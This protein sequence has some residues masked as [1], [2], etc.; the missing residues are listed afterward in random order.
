M[1]FAESN[2]EQAIDF[3]A[4]IEDVARR[5]LGEPNAHLSS[6]YD[7][8]FGAKGSVSVNT[9]KGVFRDY[10]SSVGGGTLDLIGH[11]L[12]LSRHESIQWLRQE[13]F[14]ADGIGR[15]QNVD[16]G[17]SI[18]EVL[19]TNGGKK[20][21]RPR[22]RSFGP[23]GPPRQ[24]GEIR[25]HVYLAKDGTPAKIKIKFESGRYSQWYR[26]EDGWQAKK[27]E[28][29]Q[30]VPYI[31]A[32]LD[33]F[34]PELKDDEIFWPEGEKD[35]DTLNS[36]ELPAFTFGGAGDGLP[37]D[38]T[39]YFTG[40]HLVIPADNDEPGRKHAEEKA[41]RAHA[42]GATRI[43]VFDPKT[44]WPEC[45]DG[46]DIS[47]WFARGG[48]TRERLL[49]AVE[50]LPDWQ[51]EE[52]PRADE[53]ND[54]PS[55]PDYWPTIGVAAFQGIAGDIVRTIEP[56][57]EADPVALLVQTLVMAGN[58]I[59]R[60][61]YYQVESDCHRTNLFTVLVGDSA[62]GRKGTSQGRIRSI[63][64][65]ADQSWT[66]DRIKGGLSSGEGFIEAVRDPVERYDPKEKRFEVVDPGISDK[67]LLI[68]EPEFASAISVMERSGNTLSPLIQRAWDG[69]ILAT[70]TRSPL[71]AT[72]AHISIIGHITVD[73]LRARISR[74]EM[75]NGFANRFLFA[76]VRR[77]KFLPFGGDLTDSEIEYLG[78]RIKAAIDR[79]KPVGRMNLSRG[80][81]AIWV[82]IYNYLSGAQEGL[83]GAVTA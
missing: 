36:I 81:R 53:G 75:G 11:K 64:K 15:Y 45:Q 57:S 43:R 3:A 56:H 2:F 73:E 52:Q 31:T 49:K 21:I 72:G 20:E 40:R 50:D 41:A 78:E 67:R 1:N 9:D 32:S 79:A 71:K 33:P 76:L 39:H 82:K 83:L 69:E 80:A 28:D 27:P 25:R 48:G 42:A 58:I 46:N 19:R 16:G 12:G 23:D 18:R 22:L 7:L 60:T 35:V 44:V 26:V 8:R 55:G 66:C 54:A 37:A 17:H 10:E 38:V 65:S 14:L 47:D 62:K 34:D 61:P 51:P 13:G 24:Q 68:V 70:M 30:P 59:G 6:A 77:S 5:L 74:I 63:V 4:L 29:F